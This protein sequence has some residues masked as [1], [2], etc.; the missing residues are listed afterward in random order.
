MDSEKPSQ[1]Q[2]PQEHKIKSLTLNRIMMMME[3]NQEKMAQMMTEVDLETERTKT[4][5]GPRT[6]S[7]AAILSVSTA[8]RR[9]L[10]IPPCILI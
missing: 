6:M 7:M 3:M 9:I 2:Q 10:A 1:P 5:E 8:T 4:R